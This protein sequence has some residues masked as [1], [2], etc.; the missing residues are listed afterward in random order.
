MRPATHA[1]SSSYQLYHPDHATSIAPPEREGDLVTVRMPGLFVVCNRHVL[2]RLVLDALDDGA[3]RVVLDFTATTYTDA[4]G[5]GVLLSV[6]RKVSEAG[7]RLV[8]CGLTD[9]LRT[10]MELTRIDGLF[11][12]TGTP[13]EARALL[14]V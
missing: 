12:V 5:L 4:S 9:D 1:L 3:R 7:G 8:C 11:A 14:G 13:R 2:K 10:L 6:Q